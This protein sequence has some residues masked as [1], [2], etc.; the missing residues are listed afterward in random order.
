MFGL[1][2]VS[3][4]VCE[5]EAASSARAARGLGFGLFSGCHEPEAQSTEITRDYVN[6]VHAWGSRVEVEHEKSACCSPST[7]SGYNIR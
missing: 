7:V 6:I 4:A 2:G 3:E 1:H 5:R